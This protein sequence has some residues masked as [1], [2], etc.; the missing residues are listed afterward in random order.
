L[1]SNNLVLI[2]KTLNSDTI[3]QF[4]PIAMPNFKFKIISKILAYIISNLYYHI[5]DD[6]AFVITHLY[7]LSHY[8]IYVVQYY[9]LILSYR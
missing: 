2:P 4:R 3:S 6:N 5:S 1:N 8:I 7:G 9:K